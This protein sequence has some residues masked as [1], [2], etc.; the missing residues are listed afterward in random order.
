MAGRWMG[1]AL[2]AGWLGVS[3]SAQA[4][5]PMPPASEDLPPHAFDN[6][7]PPG[8]PGPAAGGAA[9]GGPEAKGPAAGGPEAKGPAAGGPAQV[10]PG[11]DMG[12]PPF[13]AAPPPVDGPVPP[14][15]YLPENGFSNVHP[16][17][18][19]RSPRFYLGADYLLWYVRKDKAPPLLTSGS[20]SDP[21]PAALGQPGTTFLFGPGGI[22]A[23][24]SSGARV[25]AAYWF[26]QDH[27][28]GLDGTAF[29]LADAMKVADYGGNGDPN[30]PA[31]GRPF[32]NPNAQAQDA[33]PVVIPGIQSGGVEIR[34]SRQFYGGDAN[35][36]C[37][38]CTDITPFSRF[39]FLAGVRYLYLN[40]NLLFTENENDL[41]D[42]TGAP[43]DS[44]VLHDNFV[45][46]NKFYGAQ[47]GLETESRVGPLV[48]TL[49][50]KVAAGE[51][52]QKVKIQGDT[53]VTLPDGT[54]FTDQTRGLLVQPSNLGSFSRYRFAVV[55]ELIASLAWEFNDNIKVSVGYNFLFWSAVLRP[56][57]QIDPVVNV[58]AVGDTGQLGPYLRPG[59]YL[60]S[61][62][63]WA[64]GFS[65]GLMVSY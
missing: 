64:Q 34:L 65:A 1:V 54:I 19:T 59:P 60:H 6:C 45:T 55:P 7:P 36:R 21:A 4:Q 28:F 9:G 53:T 63:F 57:E 61:T 26:D 32:F 48:F 13:M 42:S 16:D 47:I 49:T 62:D 29:W 12:L 20:L 14:P 10:H 15:E 3:A 37:S 24:S 17:Q 25:T 22:G 23:A 56:A 38:M 52:N 41:P 27:T 2:L 11:P 35:L 46:Y 43:G 18:V 31:I 5:Y 40:E 8:P 58:G 50:G 39:S 33:D 30:G 44:L 51:T